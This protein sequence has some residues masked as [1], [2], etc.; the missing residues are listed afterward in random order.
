MPACGRI[1]QL[2]HAHHGLLLLSTKLFVLDLGEEPLPRDDVGP[3]VE[4]ETF[5]RQTVAP[6][7][8]DLLVP[9]L[10]IRGHVPMDYEPHVGLVDAH[11]ERD[12]S[13]DHV[14]IIP[15][16]RV[17]LPS[18]LGLLHAGMVRNR[19]HALPA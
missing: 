10:D 3:R 17:L 15:G 18:P 7:A 19:T 16:E 14:D 11:A 5:T 4:Q 8:A 2:E 9:R 12:R 13:H 6:G 1:G